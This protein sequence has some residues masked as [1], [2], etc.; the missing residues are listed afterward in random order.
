MDAG[1]VFLLALRLAHAAAATLWLGGGVYF[2]VA[3]RPA[4]READE[5][6]RVLAREIQRRFGEWAELATLVMLISGVIL[7]FERL[8]TGDGGLTYAALLGLK[9]F[10]AGIAF[11][12]AGIRPAR[13]AVRRKGARRAAPEVIVASGSLA[14]LLGVVLA[15][16]W[17]RGLS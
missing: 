14:F 16:V 1:D 8:S 13:R 9:V 4:L 5:P 12:L 17:G 6:L 11:W 15:S 2:L 3:V 10:A 7:G